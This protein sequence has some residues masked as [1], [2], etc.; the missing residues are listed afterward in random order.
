[1]Y[2]KRVTELLLSDFLRYGPQRE[3]G[4]VVYFLSLS[5]SI[6]LFLFCGMIGLIMENMQVGKSMLRKTK[7]GR[8]VNWNVEADDCLCTLKEAFE[9][10]EPSL[11]FNIELKFDDNIVYEQE[12]LTHV[13]QAMVEVKT[14]TQTTPACICV[15]KW[16]HGILYPCSLISLEFCG[17]GCVSVRQ[18][19]AN[20]LLHF[21]AGCSSACQK[22]AELLPC[23]DFI[24]S[25]LHCTC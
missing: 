18:R 19:Q 12:Y 16:A 20:N 23:K 5:L 9:K 13:L 21:P 24:Q 15:V 1:M 22:V 2:E 25:P 8:I 14:I 6:A 11:G 10:V 7:D 17:P 4:K 3:P